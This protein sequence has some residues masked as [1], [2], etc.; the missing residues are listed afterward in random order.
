MTNKEFIAFLKGVVM[1]IDT[2]PTQEQ[3]LLIVKKLSQIKD[4]SAY[5]DIGPQLIRE[6]RTEIHKI[7]KKFPGSPPNIFM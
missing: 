1:C 4:D 5:S 6:I 2:V 7:A 3:W